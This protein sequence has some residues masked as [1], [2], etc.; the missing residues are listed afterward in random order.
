MKYSELKEIIK[1]IKSNTRYKLLYLEKLNKI[2]D[3]KYLNLFNSF[4]IHKNKEKE[5]NNNIIE[6][7]LCSLFIKEVII[8]GLTSNF[9]N[10]KNVIN[11]LYDLNNLN[12]IDKDW[13]KSIEKKYN[14]DFK[15]YF[16]TL[17][18][19]SFLYLFIRRKNFKS[20]EKMKGFLIDGITSYEN[21]EFYE[22]FYEKIIQAE[23]KENINDFEFYWNSI[24]NYLMS[25]AND[26]NFVILYKA[27]KIYLNYKNEET[28]KF[29]DIDGGE[30]VFSNKYPSLI[31]YLNIYN[32]AYKKISNERTKNL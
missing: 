17:N 13:C 8:Q 20:K 2:I 28:L 16:P 14:C 23:K 27:K 31:N 15:I 30:K 25:L 4:F 12:A 21:S 9:V 29:D 22:S 6:D 19:F 7:L 24:Q 3:E 5:E 10:I 32:D 1:E 18:N 11:H 26:I